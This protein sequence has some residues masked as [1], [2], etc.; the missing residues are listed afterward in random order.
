[1]LAIA[2]AANEGSTERSI[3]AG[4]T[5]PEPAD[6]EA[7]IEHTT[8]HSGKGSLILKSTG[9]TAKDFAVR[10]RIRADGFR[11]KRVRLSGWVKPD[12]AVGGGALWL[13]VDFQNGDYVLDGM[14]ELSPTDRSVK[15]TNGWAKCDLV[16]DVPEDALGI[17]FGVRMRGKGAFWADDLA[18]D[19]VAKSIPVNTIERRPYKA[20][21]KAAAIERLKDEYSK[22]P[23]RPV[24]LGFENP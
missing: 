6:Y 3:A 13:R 15:L 4:W 19:V 22:A 21:D 12:Q 1:L 23:Q 18:F 2:Q 10:Q 8:V 7:G 20:A 24:N 16:A 9:S 11:G 14:L 5:R 17:S